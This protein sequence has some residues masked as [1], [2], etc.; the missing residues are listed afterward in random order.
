MFQSNDSGAGAPPVSF[1]YSP[2]FETVTLSM[3]GSMAALR[4]MVNTMHKR[5]LAE[6]NDW[7]K[8]QPKDHEWVTVLIRR[9]R[10]D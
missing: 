6:P 9:L 1:D 7:S 3:T 4:K 5:G 2:Q 8:P 10:I